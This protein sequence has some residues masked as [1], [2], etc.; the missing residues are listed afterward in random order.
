M[1]DFP[2]IKKKFRKK[3]KA[4]EYQHH[5]IISFLRQYNDGS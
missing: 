1:P 3:C 4:V 5:T 2:G